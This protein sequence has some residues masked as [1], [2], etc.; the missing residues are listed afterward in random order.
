MSKF[1]QLEVIE[2]Y[3]VILMYISQIFFMILNLLVFL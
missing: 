2:K 3:E 1:L